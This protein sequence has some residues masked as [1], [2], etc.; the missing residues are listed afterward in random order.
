MKVSL[1]FFSTSFT[2]QI[3]GSH[4]TSKAIHQL[5]PS[6]AMSSSSDG[7]SSGT[8]SHCFSGADTSSRMSEEDDHDCS[9]TSY[10]IVETRKVSNVLSQKS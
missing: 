1:S 10:E 5:R 7:R 6:D 2:A 8:L 9:S 4:F 3:Q